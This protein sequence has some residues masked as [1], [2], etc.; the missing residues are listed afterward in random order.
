MNRFATAMSIGIAAL[1]AAAVPTAAAPRKTSLRQDAQALVRAGVPGVVV[2]TRTAGAE[3]RIAVGIDFAT[4]RRAMLASDRFRI[5][6]VT[7]TFVAALD[8]RLADQGRLSLDDSVERWVP[9]LV[10]NGNAITLR[11][12]LR[13]TSGLFDYA[14]DP[15][16]FAPFASDPGHAWQPCDLVAL[17]TRHAPNFSPGE[18]W[19]YSNTNYVL[20]GLIVEAATG[21]PVGIELE[22]LPRADAR[23]A[24]RQAEHR[25]GA[26]RGSDCPDC[27]LRSRPSSGQDDLR[28][29]LGTRR[30]HVRVHEQRLRQR[31][32]CA[33]GDRARQ[34]GTARP[35][36]AHSF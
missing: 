6:S 32:R 8:L 4:P 24:H 14:A 18:G 5:G 15:A 34:P 17:A 29:A 7:K 35:R 26:A 16:T 33:S 10:P 22:Q 12:L 3:T 23:R 1:L 30:R 27:G 28:L 2:V 21:R 13:H 11:H 9:G 20:L 25:G 19:G 31:R 36:A